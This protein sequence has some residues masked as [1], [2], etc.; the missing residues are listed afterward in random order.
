[1]GGICYKQI[2]VSHLQTLILVRD[3]NHP[4][5]SWNCSKV[6][7]KQLGRSHECGKELLDKSDH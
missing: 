3:F 4:D 2:Q 6:G 1:M 5:I 7:H